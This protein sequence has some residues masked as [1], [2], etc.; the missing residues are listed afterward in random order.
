MGVYKDCDC[1]AAGVEPTDVGEDLAYLLGRRAGADIP[2]L[3][4]YAQQHIAHAAADQI[5]RIAPALQG[6]EYGAHIFR[7][8]D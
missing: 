6:H 7:R 2:A 5:G 3:R 8:F 1:A 4:A